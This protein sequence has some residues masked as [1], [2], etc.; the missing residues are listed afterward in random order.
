MVACRCRRAVDPLIAGFV[1]VMTV[2]RERRATALTI[3]V[4]GSG[5]GWMLIVL[6]KVLGLS[7]VPWPSD[8]LTV[9]SNTLWADSQLPVHLMGACP[10]SGGHAWGV[11]R[12]SRNKGWGYG[13]FAALA[14]AALSVPRVRPHYGLRCAQHY[15]LV[16]WTRDRRFPLGSQP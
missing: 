7:D 2:E 6:K 10:D 3:A 13:L 12:P 1:R 11:A 8:L 4:L 14:A 5:L 9:R 15:G 16:I